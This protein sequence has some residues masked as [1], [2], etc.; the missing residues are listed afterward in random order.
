VKRQEKPAVERFTF[1]DAKRELFDV[2][3]YA[4]GLVRWLA[5]REVR[6]VYGATANYFFREH[7]ERDIEDFG[8]LAM[9]LEDDI[10]ATVTGGRIGFH[11]H[12]KGGPMRVC[13]VGTQGA[14]LFDA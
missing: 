9:T 3:V 4:V 5:G 10:M 8:W 7:V 14:M 13:L 2:G 1:P 12:P 11:S 6:T